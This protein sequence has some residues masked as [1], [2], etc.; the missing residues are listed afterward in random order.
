MNDVGVPRACRPMA[1][2]PSSAGR[3]ERSHAVHRAR[4]VPLEN[5]AH[6]LYVPDNVL[7]LRRVGH[8]PCE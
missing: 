7:G 1:M 6:F 5:V 4:V 8:K 2:K 3:F